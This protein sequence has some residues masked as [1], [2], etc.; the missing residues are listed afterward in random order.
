MMATMSTTILRP[1]PAQAARGG[2]SDARRHRGGEGGGLQGSQAHDLEGAERGCLPLP[3]MPKRAPSFLCH[4]FADLEVDHCFGRHLHGFTCAW[5]PC[6]PGALEPRSKDAE[7]PQS[8]SV[9]SC[10]FFYQLI[11]ELLHY[12]PGDR[13]RAACLRGDP[14]AEWGYAL[15]SCAYHT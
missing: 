6:L 13:L 2:R 4:L 3:Q 1:A 12:G 10:Q 14:I 8:N 11:Q 9:A 15:D 7:A 5:I